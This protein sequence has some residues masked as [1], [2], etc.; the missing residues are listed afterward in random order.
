MNG[1]QESLDK[2]QMVIHCSVLIAGRQ[3]EGEE[4][5]AGGFKIAVGE[6]DSEKFESTC[7]RA[8]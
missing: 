8:F 6:W 5:V 7:H 4:K 3:E 2:F 1:S